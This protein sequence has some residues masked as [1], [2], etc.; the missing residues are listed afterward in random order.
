M[1]V[2]DARR[3]MR[4]RRR[5]ARQVCDE[6]PIFETA[7]SDGDVSTGHLDAVASATSRLD[8]NQR[9]AFGDAARRSR[10]ARR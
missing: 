3:R 8:D 2:G 4:R 9:A 7:L 10:R 6:M 1:T 5:I